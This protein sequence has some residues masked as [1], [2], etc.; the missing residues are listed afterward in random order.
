MWRSRRPGPQQPSIA[1]Y[2]ALENKTRELKAH[3]FDL[4]SCAQ[5]LHV[6]WRVA[7]SVAWEYGWRPSHVRYDSKHKGL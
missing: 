2:E 5:D 6:Q 1:D 3:I 7:A 4:Q